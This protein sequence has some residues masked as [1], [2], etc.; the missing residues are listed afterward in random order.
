MMTKDLNK[1]CH[2]ELHEKEYILHGSTAAIYNTDEKRR[3]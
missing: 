3:Q 2:V 1:T